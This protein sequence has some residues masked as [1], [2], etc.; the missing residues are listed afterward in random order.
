[1][2]D[3]DAL[4]RMNAYLATRDVACAVCGYNLR[5]VRGGVCPEC[6]VAIRF[7]QAKDVTKADAANPQ[8]RVPGVLVLATLLVMLAAFFVFGFPL[9][10]V[11]FDDPYL[12]IFVSVAALWW[13]GCVGVLIVW[14]AIAVILGRPRG[15]DE[16]QGVGNPGQSQA[17][18]APVASE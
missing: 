12:P 7:Y 9:M 10:G 16:S 2:G 5:G 11:G 3:R 17:K 15:A 13:Y 6:G 18:T 8:V 14:W 4:D 1:M